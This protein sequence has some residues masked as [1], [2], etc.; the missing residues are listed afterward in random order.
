[1]NF[2][3][4]PPHL[5]Q[6]HEWGIFKTK[7]RTPA[8]QVKGVQFT[9]HKLPFFP[10]NVAYCPKCSPEKINW[11]NIKDSALSNNCAFVRFDVPNIPVSSNNYWKEWQRKFEKHCQKAPRD[12]F[13]K[14]TIFIDLTKKDEEILAEM[15]PKTRY[16]IRLAT[17]KGVKVETRYDSEA[18]KIFLQL[19]RETADRQGFFIHPD[20]YYKTLWKTF[21]TKKM[22]HLLIASYDKK[23]AAAWCL[24]NFKGVLYYP[25]GGSSLKYKNT[26]ASN[27]IGWEAIQLGKRLGC[28]LLDMWGI[29]LNENE[30]DPWYGF[31]R[32]KRGY[33]GQIIKF[34]DSYDLVIVDWVYHLFN[35]SYKIFWR[36]LR[37]KKMLLG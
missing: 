29:T 33:G 6:S 7:M 10:F 9:I 19:Q 30:N 17:R 24:L 13:A 26:M 16:N 20:N 35:L 32:F 15:H 25:Y 5:T 3:N 31:T 23:P 21:A 36:F 1:M 18:F 2:K 8:I 28:Q 14:A 12:T 4:L 27:L 34:M 22:A 37:L 11:D